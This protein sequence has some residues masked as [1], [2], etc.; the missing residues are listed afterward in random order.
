MTHDLK[1]WPEAFAAVL[2]GSKTHEIRVA[3]R[4]FAVGD[5]LHLREYVP[6]ETIGGVEYFGRYTGRTL[7]VEVTYLS[8][9]GTWGLPPGLCVMSI[10]KVEPVS[11]WA[12]TWE[13]GRVEEQSR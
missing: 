9:G 2:D 5:R 4:P 1:T 13:T 11:E 3:D 6:I 7:D 8:A 12:A 10:R